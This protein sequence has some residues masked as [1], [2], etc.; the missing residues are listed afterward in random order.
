MNDGAAKQE[1]TRGFTKD[2]REAENG[3]PET[4][5]DPFALWAG[6]MEAFCSEGRGNEQGSSDR[7][8]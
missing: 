2:D 1:N 3:I 4:P 5:F 7:S 6:G 8:G